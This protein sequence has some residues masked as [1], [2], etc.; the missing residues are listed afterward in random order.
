[1]LCKFYAFLLCG[2]LVSALLVPL[3]IIS[4][5]IQFGS[6]IGSKPKSKS[7][8][9]KTKEE[10]TFRKRAKYFV[11]AQLVSVLLFLT[12]M[13]RSDDEVELDDDDGYGYD[14]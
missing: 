10:K 4:F 13:N 14:D 1:M 9:E 6:I 8:R 7:K 3:L 12:F 11:V 5:Y 2:I